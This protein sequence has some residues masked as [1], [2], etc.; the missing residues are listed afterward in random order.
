[1]YMSVEK[2]S[3]SLDAEL[4]ASVRAAAND[5]DVSVSTWLAEAAQARVRQRQLREVLDALA[6]EEGPLDPAEIDE[7][8]ARARRGSVVVNPTQGAA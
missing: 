4:A 3:I 1:M 8:I 5:Q 6:A 2:L 7:L